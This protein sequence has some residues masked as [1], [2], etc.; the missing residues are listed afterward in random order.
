MQIYS[1]MMGGGWNWL[2]VIHNSE[3]WC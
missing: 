3:L 1:V 2:M